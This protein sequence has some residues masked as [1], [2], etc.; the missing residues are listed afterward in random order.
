MKYTGT[1]TNKLLVEAGLSIEMNSYSTNDVEPS[2]NPTDV[3]L[4]ELTS[5]NGLNNPSLK[6]GQKLYLPAVNGGSSPALPCRLPQ[7]PA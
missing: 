4:T 7:S 6:P 5:L 2:V 1:L 3:S